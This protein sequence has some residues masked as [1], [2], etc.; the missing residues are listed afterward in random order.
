LYE[1]LVREATFIG[2]GFFGH[3]APEVTTG[4]GLEP[5]FEGSDSE[6]V[7]L[8]DAGSAV[9]ATLH[10]GVGD[11]CKPEEPASAEAPTDDG[12][13]AEGAAD[14]TGSVESDGVLEGTAVVG[15]GAVTGAKDVEARGNVQYAGVEGD[16]AARAEVEEHSLAMFGMGHSGRSRR[17][18]RNLLQRVPG[19][20]KTP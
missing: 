11:S 8:G 3:T 5:P 20:R 2:S 13:G 14:V 7:G 15:V 18:M 12:S 4:I 16:A 17:L 10:V 1:R 19:K 9:D 6:V